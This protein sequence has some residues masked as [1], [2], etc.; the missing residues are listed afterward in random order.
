MITKNL[1][2][3]VQNLVANHKS[4]Q[5]RERET[6]RENKQMNKNNMKKENYLNYTTIIKYAFCF[7][8]LL[9]FIR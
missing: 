8:F 7:L 3:K 4:Q 5:E 9:F 1:V 6:E 2:V